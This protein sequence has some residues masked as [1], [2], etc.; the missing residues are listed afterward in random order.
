MDGGIRTR[1]LG[2]ISPTQIRV[3]LLRNTVFR[4]CGVRQKLYV[5]S[6]YRNPDLDDRI[7]YC[8]LAS[9]AA[10]QAEDVSASF[11]FVGDLNGHHQEWLGSTTTNR[12]GVAAF[13][14]ATVVEISCL[15][16]QPMLVVEHFIS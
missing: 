9:M 12:H 1:W 14:F 10:V 15:S 4:V 7:S 5:Y 3:W 8:L 16:A 6:L 2:S 11:L 13:D